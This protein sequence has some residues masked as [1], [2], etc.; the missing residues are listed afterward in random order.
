MLTAGIFS[1]GEEQNVNNKGR[2]RPSSRTDLFMNTSFRSSVFRSISFPS[3]VPGDFTFLQ[4]TPKARGSICLQFRNLVRKKKAS[5][6]NITLY[7][8]A[9]SAGNMPCQRCNRFQRTRCIA[10]TATHIISPRNSRDSSIYGYCIF[11]MS[12]NNNALL[13]LRSHSLTPGK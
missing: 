5:R 3:D 13:S 11:A 1:L 7:R 6:P 12:S 2:H 8:P 10:S 9:V 4:T